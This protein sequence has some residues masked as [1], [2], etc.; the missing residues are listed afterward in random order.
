MILFVVQYNHRRPSEELTFM[1]S[2]FKF[3]GRILSLYLCV[4]VPVIIFSLLVTQ[5]SFR[6]AQQ[7]E[8]RITQQIFQE[9]AGELGSWYSDFE[10][11]AATLSVRQDMS[12]SIVQNSVLNEEAAVKLLNFAK[13]F[14]D[15]T[16]DIVIYYGSDEVYNT[17]G[18]TSVPVYFGI[19][20]N[21]TEESVETAVEALTAPSA[22]MVL[23]GAERQQGYLLYHQ[24]LKNNWMYETSVQFIVSLDQVMDVLETHAP[25]S[26]FIFCMKVG[27]KEMYLQVNEGKCSV[28]GQ[29]EFQDLKKEQNRIL[30]SEL[31]QAGMELELHF[32]SQ[33]SWA[34][35]RWFQTVNLC[36]L[37]VGIALSVLI[38]VVLSR[39]RWGHFRSLTNAVKVD[40]H[41]KG[42]AVK[43]EFS[44][45]RIMLEQSQQECEQMEKNVQTYRHAMIRQTAMM[46]FHGMVSKSDVILRL[47]H[48]CDQEL[49]EDYY[50]LCGV[51]LE[52]EGIDITQFEDF[53]AN[54]LYCDS[55]FEN[56]RVLFLLAESVTQDSDCTVRMD[57][58]N[59]LCKCLQTDKKMVS[60]VALSQIYDN[61]SMVNYAYLE[62]V[63]LLENPL[64]T[65]AFIECWDYPQQVETER[66]TRTQAEQLEQFIEF[67]E[68]RDSVNAE[69]TLYNM[70]GNDGQ[71]DN[72]GIT[73]NRY[74]L[75]YCIRQA[76]ILALRGDDS[77]ECSELVE[78]IILINPA[79]EVSFAEQVIKILRAYSVNDKSDELL[80]ATMEYM[81]NNYSRFDLSKEDVLDHVGINK[82]QMSRL[83]KEKLGI[84]Y[85]DYLTKLRMDKAKDLVLNTDQSVKSILQAVGYID[86]TSFT[87]KF[88]AYY[89]MSP[90]EYRCQNRGRNTMD[91]DD[92]DI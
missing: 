86:Q 12:L 25:T 77:K 44:Y 55:L 10:R 50:Y 8:E 4:L 18:L 22:L 57:M 70:L 27:G 82:T 29:D 1:V 24:P 72:G 15:R 76:L 63:S 78:K 84:G 49:S 87:K 14:S 61:L 42:I 71:G 66:L 19:T 34:V 9:I 58:A 37:V 20:L 47:L 91:E 43:D 73:D 67:L 85:L 39:Q 59:R 90:K 21:C 52:D 40:L 13:L 7:R 79:S 38:S 83:F 31:P 2:K 92:A 54:Y 3:I 45:I 81:Q 60:R 36:L 11:Q 41:Q 75:R 48:S 89:G 80:K 17:D 33:Q 35:L 46:I 16:Q 69:E 56:K 6:Q 74:Y 5:V 65:E 51:V 53:L 64:Q 26:Q 68:K 88:K 23:L 28:L 62:V 32:D 30:K